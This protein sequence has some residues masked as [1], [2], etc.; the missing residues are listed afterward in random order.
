MKIKHY[1]IAFFVLGMSFYSCSEDF[2]DVKN[3]EADVSVGRLY[4]TYTYMGGVVWNTYSY[5]PDGLGKLYMEAATDNA[6]A[7]NE[8][9]SSQLFN[10][11][12]WDEFLNTDEVMLHYFSGIRQASLFLT[13]HK[14]VSIDYI[15][16]GIIGTD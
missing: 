11:G 14:N 7:T 8:S 3:V 9:N 5:L 13:N 6:E 12:N 1:L 2:L 4:S 15:K 10:T 16:N